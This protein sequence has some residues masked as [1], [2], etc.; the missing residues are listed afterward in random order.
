MRLPPWAIEAIRNGVADVARKASDTETIARVK[1][2]AAEL[3]RDL[4]ENAS[5]SI[6]A[7]VK[8]ASE[9]ARGAIDQGRES[10]LRW[11]ERQTDLAVP[12][13]NAG[14]VLLARS[15]TGVPVSDPV[16]QLG[17]DVLRGDCVDHDLNQQLSRSLARL[18][19]LD[20][21]A[22][23]VA[24]SLDAAIASLTVLAQQREFVMHRSQAI[25]LPSGT[26]L[27]DAL[28]GLT[29]REC[30]GVQAIEPRDFDGIDHA[31]VILADDGMHPI[32]P[33]DFKGRDVISIAVLPVGT[34]R[35]AHDSIPSAQVLLQSGIDLVLLPGGPLTGGTAAG[36]LAGK[37]TLIDS[38]Q[39]DARWNTHKAAAGIVAM[40]LAAMT[41]SNPSPFSV[42]IDTGEENLRSR[43]ER[44]AIRLTAD[45]SI[46]GCQITDRPARLI[47]GGRWEFP[48]RQ[49]NLRHKTLSAQQ[50]CDQLAKQNPAVITGIDGEHLVIDLRWLPASADSA[51]AAALGSGES[52]PSDDAPVDVPQV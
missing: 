38:I 51:T 50:W 20:G 2:Q 22:I 6:D 47:D 37:K 44:M 25:R 19:D 18:L 31:C 27:P 8:T 34:I 16:L 49:L 33:I 48:S 21:H 4:P 5:R 30:G 10:M 28:A 14:G 7:L 12:C 45:D 13:I 1:A 42:L 46:T 43:A 39:Q 26:P 17:A 9:T 11:T 35:Q 41:D 36:I 29:L 24:T 52:S 40:T 15:G 23:A 3:L 32:G